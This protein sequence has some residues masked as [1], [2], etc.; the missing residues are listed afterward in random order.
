MIF[1]QEFLFLNDGFD[2]VSFVLVVTGPEV[3]VAVQVLLFG[4]PGAYETVHEVLLFVGDVLDFV[5]VRGSHAS[6]AEQ[7]L[8]LLEGRH[9]LLEDLVVHVG[10]HLDQL[11]H[12]QRVGV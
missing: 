1:A 6:P 8:V 3:P 2:V 5:E 9:V 10:S 12:L 7:T 4:V 11:L